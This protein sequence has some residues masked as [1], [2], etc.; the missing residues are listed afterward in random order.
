MGRAHRCAP[1]LVCSASACESQ[2]RGPGIQRLASKFPDSLSVTLLCNV[3]LAGLV[4]YMGGKTPAQSLKAR[5]GDFSEFS[6]NRRPGDGGNQSEPDQ[7]GNLQATRS[8]IIIIPRYNFIE[9]WIFMTKL[10][11]DGAN[12]Q[13][14]IRRHFLQNN[15]RAGFDA[16]VRLLDL[17]QCHGSDSHRNRSASEY[18]TSSS[19]KAAPRALDAM[20]RNSS[21]S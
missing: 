18:S 5:C 21:R 1:L 4:P 7:G 8:E 15:H 13:I 20:L 12:Q 10:G 9:A 3:S 11:T 17:R 14:A 6:K 19:A 16:S 2:T